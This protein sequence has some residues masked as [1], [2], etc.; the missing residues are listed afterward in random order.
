MRHY[1]NELIKFEHEPDNKKQAAQTHDPNRPCLCA[2]R[3]TVILYQLYPEEPEIKLPDNPF[4]SIQG[5]APSV[6][7]Y[8]T[9]QTVFAKDVPMWRY[10]TIL[11]L[12]LLAAA[13]ATTHLS[14][15][16]RSR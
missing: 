14:N 2:G 12:S 5:D 9:I 3:H 13:W 8:N 15:H 4:R 1:R 7:I 6:L 10:L 16:R 11:I